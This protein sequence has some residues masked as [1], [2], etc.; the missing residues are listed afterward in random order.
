[1]AASRKP[2]TSSTP[3]LK[4]VLNG[5][6]DM[7]ANTTLLT[8]AAH[9]QALP[10]HRSARPRC[11]GG[12]QPQGLPPRAPPARNWRAN[13][14]A[15]QTP[16][17]TLALPAKCPAAPRA[18][19]PVPYGATTRRPLPLP[20]GSPRPPLC[21]LAAPHAVPTVDITTVLRTPN[22]PWCGRPPR[23]VLPACNVSL[24][25]PPPERQCRASAKLPGVLP[26]PS[27][28]RFPASPPQWPRNPLPSQY[29]AEPSFVANSPNAP[30]SPFPLPLAH[31]ELQSP[32]WA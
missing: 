5:R 15:V 24:Q 4:L 22:L 1:M 2:L 31:P 11:P 16:L 23:T 20:A 12:P 27:P 17:P 18:P 9:P 28:P 19:S 14:A 30:P 29:R 7:S 21:R 8:S 10:P 25:S 32:S 6:P 13:T 26:A 3:F